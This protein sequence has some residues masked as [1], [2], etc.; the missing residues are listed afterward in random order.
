[1]VTATASTIGDS[2]CSLAW[3]ERLAGVAGA[4]VAAGVLAGDDVGLTERDRALATWARRV[5]GGAGRTSAEDVQELRDAGLTDADVVSATVYVALRMAFSTVNGA[6]GAAPDAEL[7]ARTPA[8]VVA[9]VTWGRPVARF[10]PEEA[11]PEDAPGH[12]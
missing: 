5:A 8:E 6:L 1:M 7:A 2:Y 3:G 9:A 10:A 12:P 4:E 11:S